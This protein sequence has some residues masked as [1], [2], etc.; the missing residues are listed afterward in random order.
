MTLS[1][2]LLVVG[3]SHLSKLFLGMRDI[4][5]PLGVVHLRRDPLLDL[6]GDE[7][8]GGG[9]GVLAHLHMIMKMTMVKMTMVMMTTAMVMVIGI[10]SSPPSARSW[11]Q[12][13]RPKSPEQEKWLEFQRHLENVLLCGGG[14]ES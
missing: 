2:M 11:F 13:C 5:G 12:A 9:V 14:L 10:E 4:G 7:E 3:N 1:V 8:E 6:L